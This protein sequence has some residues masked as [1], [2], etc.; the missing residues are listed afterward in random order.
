MQE[1]ITL[2]VFAVFS[3]GVLKEQVTIN[4]LI[5]FSL[6]MAGVIRAR[7][8]FTFELKRE[9]RHLAHYLG[10]AFCP[11]SYLVAILAFNHDAQQWLSA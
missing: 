2:V 9:L 11:M 7:G 4:H 5:G 1:V 3:V 10:N 8:Y 6:I